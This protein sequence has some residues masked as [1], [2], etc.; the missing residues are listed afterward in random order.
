[1]KQTLFLLGCLFFSLVN[2]F[3]HGGHEDRGF[4]YVYKPEEDV[5]SWQEIRVEGQ[6]ESYLRNPLRFLGY[7]I[8]AFKKKFTAP[9]EQ[10]DYFN[11]QIKVFSLLEEENSPESFANVTLVGDLMWLRNGWIGFLEENLKRNLKSSDFLFAN[12]ET[13]ISKSHDVPTWPPARATFNSPPSIIDEFS[14]EQGSFFSALSVANNHSLDYGELGFQETLEILK[15]RKIPFSGVLDPK[16]KSTKKRWVSVEENGIK[17]GFYAA[18]YGMNNRW[19]KTSSL[20]FNLIKGVAPFRRKPKV[21]LSELEQVLH[22]MKLE[23]VDL[24]VVS[25][26]WGFEYEYYPEPM[27]MV[28]ARDIVRLGADMIMGHHS[29]SQQPLEVCFVNHSMPK[30]IKDSD[31]QYCHLH[32]SGKPRKALIAYGLGNFLTNMYGFL[33]EVG[34]ILNVELVKNQ[35]GELQWQKPRMRFVYNNRDY[36]DTDKRRLYYLSDYLEDNCHRK[37][38]RSDQ[39]EEVNFLKSLYFRAK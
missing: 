24:K 4:P 15:Q 12:L 39:I 22:E 14:D 9:K 25:L 6:E 37:R 23:K 29:H 5:K 34:G 26:H 11:D 28:V 2:I 19:E 30:A 33:S 32:D 20:D 31:L 7:S 10:V 16:Y 1:M 38:C 18:T 8:K 27:Q 36:K 21:D 35:K 13:L 3:A 17:V